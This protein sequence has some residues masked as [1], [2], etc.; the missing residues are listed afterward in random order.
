MSEDPNPH[1]QKDWENLRPSAMN[2]GNL[3]DR[4]HPL[5]TLNDD[6]KDTQND[7]ANATPR[8]QDFD[9]LA[10]HHKKTLSRFNGI[11]QKC[12]HSAI[13]KDKLLDQ[14]VSNQKSNSDSKQEKETAKKEFQEK[15]CTLENYLTLD[16]DPSAAEM[17][18][19]WLPG[20]LGQEVSLVQP[21]L[22]ILLRS[23]G[24]VLLQSEQNS[25]TTSP[26][27]AQISNNRPIS[28]INH[29]PKRI[30]DKSIVGN[31]SRFMYLLRDDGIKITV[32]EKPGQRKNETPE[33][34]RHQCVDQVMSH[35]AKHV[36]I[37]FNLAGIGVDTRATGVVLTPAY[38]KLIQLRLENMGTEKVRLVPLATDCLPLMSI[39]NFDKWCG[40]KHEAKWENIRA[41][42]Y[43]MADEA[44][45]NKKN[46]STSV[47]SGLVALCNLM[48]STRRKLFGNPRFVSDTLNDLIGFGYFAAVYEHMN[49]TQVVKLSR[50]GATKILEHETNVL[51]KLKQDGKQTNGVVQLISYK[52][53]SVTLGGVEIHL[54]G[55]TLE[56]RGVPL[57]MYLASLPEENCRTEKLQESGQQLEKALKFVHEHKYLHNDISPKN[58]MIHE[59]QAFLIDFGIASMK[60][61]DIY[62]FRG[63]AQ[64]AHRSIFRKYPREK[65]CSKE[66]YDNTG[67]A[68]SMAKLSAIMKPLWRSFQP[69]EYKDKCGDRERAFDDWAKGRSEIA[70]K[71]LKDADFDEHWLKWCNDGVAH[72]CLE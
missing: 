31:N 30:A 36:G 6:D 9:S 18:P 5:T 35:L 47:P 49:K 56:P 66:E 63:T 32:E 22:G 7:S 2:L 71:Y 11:L 10:D 65:W 68:F 3:D 15:L 19:I 46:D 59:E 58:M 38:V 28:A 39:E 72:G 50:Y 33:D 20:P 53:E 27:K 60:N 12:F 17:E 67:L 16:E 54:K 40:T 1:Q 42:L 4:F 48:A 69:F 14:V 52:D 44:A 34:L 70:A 41:E 43:C 24:T 25:N 64:F 45:S 13:F 29:R 55:L 61:E 23:L 57:E 8:I 21:F 51:E 26:L 62:G 37:G